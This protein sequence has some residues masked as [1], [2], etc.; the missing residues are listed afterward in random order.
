VEPNDDFTEPNPLGGSVCGSLGAGD[1]QDW[2]KWSSGGPAP[3]D[4]RLA[5]AGDAR[6]S[7]WK[8]ADGLYAPV[9]NT[10]SVEIAHAAPAGGSYVVVV[11]TFSDAV[12]PY[13]LTL[14]N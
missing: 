3:Y 9:E 4:L 1:R 8:I 10:S 5:T 14:T 2:Y 13:T 12:Q 11:S 7:M 6:L